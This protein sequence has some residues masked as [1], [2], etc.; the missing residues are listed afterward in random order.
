M[1]DIRILRVPDKMNLS[2]EKEH[3]RL[4]AE[5]EAGNPV[6]IDEP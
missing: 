1:N 2:T 6:M 4:G 5:G 3:F